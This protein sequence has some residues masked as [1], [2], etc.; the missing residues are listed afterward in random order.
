MTFCAMSRWHPIA[1]IVTIAPSISNIVRSL[2][3]AMISLDFSATLTCPST[4]RWPA[5]KADTM[6]IG[7][8]PPLLWPDRRTV[9]PSTA[10]TPTGTPVTQATKQRLQAKRPLALPFHPASPHGT[11]GKSCPGGNPQIDQAQFGVHEVEI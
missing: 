10:T 11:F 9:L 4:T 8:L 2:G 6:W 1:S 5:A 3:I 7:A